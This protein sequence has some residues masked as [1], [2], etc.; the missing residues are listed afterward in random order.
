M[1]AARLP[2][3]L[4]PRRERTAVSQ[5]QERA[6]QR[7]ATP[8]TASSSKRKGWDL[9]NPYIAR[10]HPGPTRPGTGNI[11]DPRGGRTRPSWSTR[12][13]G[14]KGTAACAPCP[15]GGTKVPQGGVRACA[16]KATRPREQ[17]RRKPEKLL[18]GAPNPLPR[19]VHRNSGFYVAN[20][21]FYT[22][23]TTRSLRMSSWLPSPA[24]V[25]T[26]ISGRT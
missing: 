19:K 9:S 23:H 24:E 10:L 12:G 11:P 5:E 15:Q 16:E 1:P 21:A 7:S 17:A 8:T 20:F 18:S 3:R 26:S 2:D 4:V 13:V 25:S 6:N 22:D 14:R